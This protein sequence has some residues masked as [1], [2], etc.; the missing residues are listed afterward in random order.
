[1]F[2]HVVRSTLFWQMGTGAR[3]GKW[4]VL[5]HFWQGHGFR[6]FSGSE[7]QRH[8]KVSVGLHGLK[9]VDF[10]FSS[11]MSRS[12]HLPM[13]WC[14]FRS[15]YDGGFVKFNDIDIESTVYNSGIALIELY[16]KHP[17]YIY[18]YIYIYRER[19]SHVFSV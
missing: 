19:H 16:V 15:R 9:V 1:M 4:G 11:P 18:I 6:N 13:S 3:R 12:Q 8:K 17:I 7:N 2:A 10:E 5:H 14:R